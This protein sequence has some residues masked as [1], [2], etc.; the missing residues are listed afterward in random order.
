MF[1]HTA[2]HASWMNPLEIWF[3]ILMRKLVKR[4]SFTSVDDLKNKV[5]RSIDY[6]NRKMAKPFIWPYQAKGACG[7]NYRAISARL[8]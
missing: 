4:D 3:S 7:L 2:K 1:H 6:Y 8:C 5:V